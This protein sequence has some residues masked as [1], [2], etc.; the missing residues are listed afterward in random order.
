M[1]D[2]GLRYRKAVANQSRARS[3][4]QKDVLEA[5]HDHD[6]GSRIHQYR[7]NT[8]SNHLDVE[9]NGQQERA[10]QAGVEE[11]RVRRR[12]LLQKFHTAFSYP[13]PYF[14]S[15]QC[16][17][18][19]KEPYPNIVAEY[20]HGQQRLADGEPCL[21]VQSLGLDGAEGSIEEALEPVGNA[22]SYN[23]RKIEQEL[24]SAGLA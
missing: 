9:R 8:V 19:S 4:R 17:K 7:P 16:Q 21:V 20:G 24:V 2:D 11:P 14:A 1:G 5:K 3:D 6:A 22:R 12:L 15:K 23:E 10:C 18:H 13:L